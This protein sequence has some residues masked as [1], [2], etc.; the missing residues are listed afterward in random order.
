MSRQ[1]DEAATAALNKISWRLILEAEQALGRAEIY[2]SSKR[3]GLRNS[4]PIYLRRAEAALQALH[5]LEDSRPDG[6]SW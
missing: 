4:V 5:H 3:Q 6:W 1:S 2:A